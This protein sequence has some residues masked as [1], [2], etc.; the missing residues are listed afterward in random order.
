[1]IGID[2]GSNTLRACKMDENGNILWDFERIV[3]SARNMD[4]NGLAADAKERII[5][6]LNELKMERDLKGQYFAAATAA[7]RKAKNAPE[8]LNFLKNELNIDF[9]VISGDDE[10]AFVRKGINARLKKLGISDKNAVFIDLGGASTEIS[11]NESFKSFDFGIVSYVNTFKN[12]YSNVCKV[13]S[14]AKDFISSF[15][16]SSVILSSGVSTSMAALKIGLNYANYDAK[17]VNGLRLENND[18]DEIH[19]KII[20]SDDKEALVGKGRADILCA[21][22]M[23]LKELLSKVNAPFV[24]IDDGLREGLCTAVFD[25][26]L[27][28]KNFY[29]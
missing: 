8:F 11:Y 18:F 27:K 2:L 6:A 4:E 5:K 10:A 15:D 19:A 20:A 17:K 14:V 25:D 9:S 28:A 13:V 7:F 16:I 21:G 26:S 22:I 12:D 1:M 23:L 29:F 3:G 24:V